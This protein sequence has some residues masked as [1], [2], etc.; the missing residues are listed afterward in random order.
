MFSVIS[1]DFSFTKS[2]TQFHTCIQKVQRLNVLLGSTFD[3][4]HF[5]RVQLVELSEM[6][7]V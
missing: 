1:L 7:K 6:H 4:L 3:S 5:V 2:L